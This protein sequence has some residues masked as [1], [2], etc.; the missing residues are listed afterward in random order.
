MAELEGTPSESAMTD[1]PQLT[2]RGQDPDQNHHDFVRALGALAVL[3]ATLTPL[4]R[5][6]T[7]LA[8]AAIALTVVV[9]VSVLACRMTK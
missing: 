2:N 3:M 1:V 9:T 7:N 6:V 4:V 8:T 5:S